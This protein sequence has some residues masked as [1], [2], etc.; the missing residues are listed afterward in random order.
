MHSSASKGAAVPA[1]EYCK[2]LLAWIHDTLLI[3]DSSSRIFSEYDNIPDEAVPEVR[4]ELL[5]AT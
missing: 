2:R 1:R 3:L 4:T 5:V